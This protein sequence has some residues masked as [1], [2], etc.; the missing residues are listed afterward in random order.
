MRDI[1]KRLAN[2]PVWIRSFQ[3]QPQVLEA[4]RLAGHIERTK[5]AR[6]IGRN[7]VGLTAAGA[8]HYGLRVHRDNLIE[9]LMERIRPKRP[10]LSEADRERHRDAVAEHVAEGG[11]LATAA[12]V[13]GMSKAYCQLRWAEIRDGLGWQAI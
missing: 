3:H 10:K 11:T 2:G 5:P 7:M 8:A 4:M 1:A 6:G 13:I 9:P 12:A